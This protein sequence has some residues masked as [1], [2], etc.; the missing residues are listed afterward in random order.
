MS[1]ADKNERRITWV[2][3]QAH[4]RTVEIAR[5][6]GAELVVFDDQVTSLPY[7]L[8]ATIKTIYRRRSHIILVQN[9]SRILAG[10]ASILKKILGFTLVVDRHTNFRIGRPIGWDPRIWFVVLCSEI[11]IRIADLTIVTNKFLKDL[12]ERKGGK[13]YVLPDRIP[14]ETAKSLSALAEQRVFSK[15]ESL[16][17]HVV[18]IC[19]FAYDEPF[20]EVISA[21][22]LLP[23]SV[24]VFITGDSS[25]AL[26]ADEASQIPK[27]VVLTGFISDADYMALLED[28]D[29]VLDFTSLEWCLVCGGYEALALGKPFVTSDTEA[30]KEFYEGVAVHCRHTASEI[31]E[32]VEFA[33]VSSTRLSK[34]MATLREKKLKEWRR[35]FQSLVEVIDQIEGSKKV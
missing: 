7:R 31:A 14:E 16:D 22:G 10:L 9:P 23:P 5:E 19:T 34:E 32:A 30:L 13:A 12:V 26:G 20:R 1:V 8:L 21:A 2:T 29:A 28:A 27:N 4:R 6:L 35:L 33:L 15:T 11:S 3:W 18:M 24:T 17:N 25:R